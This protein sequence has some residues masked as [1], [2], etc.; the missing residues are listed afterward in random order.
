[1][2]MTNATDRELVFRAQ[3]RCCISWHLSNITIPFHFL[4][5]PSNGYYFFVFNS[6][7]E[8][9]TNFIKAR[10][11]L[12]KTRYDVA[13]T[14]LRECMNSTN[15]CDLSLDLFSSQKVVLEVPLRNNDSLWNEQFVI[16]SECEPRKSLYLAC[17]IAVPILIMMFAFQ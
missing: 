11:D 8:V 16:I 10:F 1:M 6:E 3:K 13:K 5:V 2:T 9:Q 15:K 4:R 17:V 12:Q 14:K 7:N